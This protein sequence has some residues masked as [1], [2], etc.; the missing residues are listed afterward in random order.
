VVSDVDMENNYRSE[1][2]LTGPGLT[3]YGENLYESHDNEDK[4]IKISYILSKNKDSINKLHKEKEIEELKSELEAL[5]KSQMQG[6]KL[7]YDKEKENL[8]KKKEQELEERIRDSHRSLQALYDENDPRKHAPLN[9]ESMN[10]TNSQPPFKPVP[11]MFQSE[12]N[13]RPTHSANIEQS[14]QDFTQIKSELELKH[15]MVDNKPCLDDFSKYKNVEYNSSKTVEQIKP[16][17]GSQLSPEEEMKQKMLYE[18][19]LRQKKLEEMAK[20]NLSQHMSN[21]YFKV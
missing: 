3:V 11:N 9:F 19:I 6:N 8:I 14:P 10:P 13:F 5:K 12:N 20:S 16:P 4:K 7:M 2:L 17:F 18:E 1:Y 15:T 21:I